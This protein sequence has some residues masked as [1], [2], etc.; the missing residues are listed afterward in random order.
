MY[1][2][3][4]A[5]RI[6]AK[7]YLYFCQHCVIIVAVEDQSLI[8]SVTCNISKITNYVLIWV[9]LLLVMNDVLDETEGVRLDY[10]ITC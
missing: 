1:L 4:V 3:N 10:W 6:L 2:I 7:S 8:C 9:S 5:A